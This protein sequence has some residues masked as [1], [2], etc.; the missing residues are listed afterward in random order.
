MEREMNYEPF[1]WDAS[2]ACVGDVFAFARNGKDVAFRVMIRKHQNQLYLGPELQVWTWDLWVAL[3][4]SRIQRT[5]RFSN[6]I[7]ILSFLKH[8]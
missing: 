6:N 7:R 8:K 5:R 4:G 3:G 2:D 1:V